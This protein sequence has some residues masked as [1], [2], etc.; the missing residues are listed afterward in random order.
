MTKQV[1]DIF[2]IIKRRMESTRD[3]MDQFQKESMLLPEVED[4]CAAMAL[5]KNLNPN[6]L[7]A[8]RRLKESLCEFPTKTRSDVYHRYNTKLHIEE[9]ISVLS[10]FEG[11]DTSGYDPQLG[12]TRRQDELRHRES[13]I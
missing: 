6:S 1:E 3:F 8:S 13:R 9:D 2:K 12:G 7:E 10:E 5:S 11:K 4:N